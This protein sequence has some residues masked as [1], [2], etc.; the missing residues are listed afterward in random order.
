MDLQ[1]HEMIYPEFSLH[2]REDRHR[3]P[4]SKE[5]GTCGVRVCFRALSVSDR[6]SWRIIRLRVMDIFQHC[7][8]L[9]DAGIGG[10]TITGQ[11]KQV[12]LML[13]STSDSSD[14]SLI[15]SNNTI[16]AAK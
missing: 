5:A 9:A 12:E 4:I 16:V 13:Y 6:S 10:T 15:A 1:R 2:A 8:S 11:H 3:L 7:V 14:L